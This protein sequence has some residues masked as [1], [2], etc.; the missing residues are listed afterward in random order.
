MLHCATGWDNHH[1]GVD[2]DDGRTGI[3]DHAGP[4]YDVPGT[5]DDGHGPDQLYD[6]RALLDDDLDHLAVDDNV[7]D[8]PADDDPV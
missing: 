7:D 5:P 8:L 2:D 6:A 3:D 4:K 1:H